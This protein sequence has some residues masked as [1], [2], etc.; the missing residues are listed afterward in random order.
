[1]ASLAG[2]R[3]ACKTLREQLK[4]DGKKQVNDVEDVVVGAHL[5][6]GETVGTLIISSK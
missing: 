6:M 5:E 2:L 3:L 1:V 4:H